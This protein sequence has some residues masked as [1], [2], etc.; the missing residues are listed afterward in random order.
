MQSIPA[1]IWFTLQLITILKFP[2]R[3][4][5]AKGRKF[6][7]PLI[8]RSLFLICQHRGLDCLSLIQSQSNEWKKSF[9]NEIKSCNPLKLFFWHKF[10]RNWIF[11]QSWKFFAHWKLFKGILHDCNVG[12]WFLH[13]NFSNFIRLSKGF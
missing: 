12:E 2:S 6:H 9:S 3:Y 10:C 7:N 8:I 13:R 4:E 11:H 1:I 5:Q